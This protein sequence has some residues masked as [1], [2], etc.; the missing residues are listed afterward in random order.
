MALY[1]F[2]I[3]NFFYFVGVIS[4]L[5]APALDDVMIRF[6]VKFS[7]GSKYSLYGKDYYNDKRVFWED[8]RSNL[9]GFCSNVCEKGIPLEVYDKELEVTTKFKNKVEFENWFKENQSPEPCNCFEDVFDDQ[10]FYKRGKKDISEMKD[11]ISNEIDRLKKKPFNVW[12]VDSGYK[13]LKMKSK[14]GLASIKVI[15]DC[16]DENKIDEN[17]IKELELIYN[18]PNQPFIES[19]TLLNYTRQKH[20]NIDPKDLIFL[21]QKN[22]DLII[23]SEQKFDK[24]YG[25]IK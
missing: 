13:I 17:L 4:I 15:K 6:E 14:V 7:N 3:L 2:K 12:S 20:E 5:S 10:S 8:H 23:K 24:T 18:I 19:F 21:L 1:D 22:L 16:W 11:F 9:I 25:R